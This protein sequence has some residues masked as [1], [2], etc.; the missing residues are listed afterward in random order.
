MV[1]KRL[2]KYLFTW[3]NGTTVGTN[4]FTFLKGKKVGEDYLGNFYYESKDQEKRWCIYCDQSEASRISPEWN[5]WLRF[6]SNTVPA[7]NNIE[8]D[9]QK[10]FKGNPTGLD[11]AYKP[12][13]IRAGRLDKDLDNYQSDYKAWKPE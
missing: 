13:I 1:V 12:S 5:S 4:L 2:L 11:S 7:G 9:W 6:T 10:I 8:Y 3:W